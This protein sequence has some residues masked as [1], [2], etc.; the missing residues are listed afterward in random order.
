MDQAIRKIRAPAV[1]GTPSLPSSMSKLKLKTSAPLGIPRPIP[2]Q[3]TPPIAHHF[4]WSLSPP[5][6]PTR[7]R[8]R[9][10]APL[11]AGARGGS[12]A[13]SLLLLACLGNRIAAALAASYALVALLSVVVAP[14][15][16]CLVTLYA[17]M[18]GPRRLLA[19]LLLSLHSRAGEFVWFNEFCIM[20]H[21][22][23]W[24]YLF[25]NV[26]VQK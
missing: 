13:G 26:P 25:I 3:S 4:A 24:S 1:L 15:H 12:R 9:A 22:L 14:R 11:V 23:I 2:F 5:P 18:M 7:S 19:M 10:L 20:S 17:P 8:K 16:C 21:C 6:N